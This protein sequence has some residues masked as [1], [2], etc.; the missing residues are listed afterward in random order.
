M[1]DPTAYFCEGFGDWL[2]INVAAQGLIDSL[3]D[4]DLAH[5]GVDD[6]EQLRTDIGE[7]CQGLTYRWRTIGYRLR[8]RETEYVQPSPTSREP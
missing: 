4:L 1:S 2:E 7:L 8:E 5:L 3:D 6:L